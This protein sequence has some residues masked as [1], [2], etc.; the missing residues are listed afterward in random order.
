MY[1]KI[2]L[3][4]NW[5]RKKHQYDNNNK[6]KPHTRHPANMKNK[7]YIISS[8]NSHGTMF[9]IKYYYVWYIIMHNWVTISDF[10]WLIMTSFVHHAHC[11]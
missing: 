3:Q 2:Q 1:E 11:F 7:L 9:W 4:K 10:T 6:K 5:A 8:P